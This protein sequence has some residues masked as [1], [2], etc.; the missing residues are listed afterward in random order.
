MWKCSVLVSLVFA[1]QPCWA[2]GS[3][4]YLS[5]PDLD[6]RAR[7]LV[8]TI[9]QPSGSASLQSNSIGEGLNFTS[10]ASFGPHEVS[11][12]NQSKSYPQKFSIDRAKLILKRETTSSMSGAVYTETSPCTIVKAPSNNKF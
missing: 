11:W 1:S 5:C 8:V 3:V 6:E 9:D 10:P 12:R 7:D 2:V 4:T